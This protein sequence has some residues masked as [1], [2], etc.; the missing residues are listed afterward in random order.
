M[1]IKQRKI[2][3]VNDKT[4]I[5]RSALPEDARSLIEH[6]VITSGETYFLGRYPE[7]VT[8]DI[9]FIS[10][11]IADMKSSPDEFMITAF[12]G[13]R[14]IG[15]SA[16]TRLKDRIKY[17]HRAYFGISIQ[18]EFC[19]MGLGTA[20]LKTAIEN[21]AIGF[22]QLELGVFSNNTAAVHLYEKCGFKSFGTQPRAFKLKDGRY[23]DEIIMVKFLNS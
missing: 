4:I 9:N 15:D 7:E 10:K 20:M 22:E 12:D 3:L 2:T 13:D 1:M 21:A 18:K 16:V 5:I 14:V 11:F 19:G 8:T 23:C 6:R 17:R